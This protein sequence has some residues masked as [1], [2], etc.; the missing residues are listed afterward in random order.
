MG[1]DPVIGNKIEISFRPHGEGTVETREFTICGLVKNRRQHHCDCRQ[2]CT[3]LIIF[4][5]AYG[6]C[7]N[8]THLIPSILKPLENRSAILRRELGMEEKVRNLPN[9]LSGGQQQRTAIARAI[10]A[11][12]SIILADERRSS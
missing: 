3:A 6:K 8:R 5:P 11:K 10:A 2:D 7:F 12:P 9:T 4:Y 1:V